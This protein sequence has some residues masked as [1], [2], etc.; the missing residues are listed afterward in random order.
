MKSQ[1]I[2][3]QSSKEE[4][5]E[6]AIQS[7]LSKIRRYQQFELIQLKSA[8]LSRLDQVEKIKIESEMLIKHIDPFDYVI[9]FDQ[10]G[11]LITSENFSSELKKIKL[12]G[13]SKKLVFIVG[14]AFGVTEELRN[15]ANLLVSLSKMILNH[16][17]ALVVVLE[18][19]YRAICIEKNLPYHNP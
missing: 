1:L 14:G 12:H 17:V 9:L 11:T 4:W 19:V 3:V 2:T 6:G 7:F 18:Q 10:R 13:S 16:H 5:L 15:R 8:K